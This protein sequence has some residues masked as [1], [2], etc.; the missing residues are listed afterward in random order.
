VL[1]VLGGQRRLESLSGTV[2]RISKLSS[3]LLKI[4][5][6]NLVFNT[7]FLIASAQ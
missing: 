3:W 1:I 5:A 6:N 7:Q 2:L 4:N